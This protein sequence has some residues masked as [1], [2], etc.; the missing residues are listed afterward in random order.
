MLSTSKAITKQ[1]SV[2]K[3]VEKLTIDLQ[4]LTADQ[5]RNLI[6]MFDSPEAYAENF[7]AV[8][9][10]TRGLYK[11]LENTNPPERSPI[12]RMF[13]TVNN[14]QGTL[15]LDEMHEHERIITDS[16]LMPDAWYGF[17]QK[18]GGPSC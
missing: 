10:I 7:S 17:R 2:S 18:K 4:Y 3:P 1:N 6:Q 12:L 16:Y 8:K 5:A 11:L 13:H 15:M 14:M 9:A